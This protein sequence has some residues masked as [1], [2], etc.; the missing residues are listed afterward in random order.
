MS[1]AILPPSLPYLDL[2]GN[3]IQS[4]FIWFGVAGS[5]ASSNPIVVYWDRVLTQPASQPI[6]ILNGYTYRAGTMANVFVNA[7]DYSITI[8]NK[9]NEVVFATLS[10]YDSGFM[11]LPVGGTVGLPMRLNFLKNTNFTQNTL[12]VSGTIVLTAGQYGHNNY[13]AG[14]AG[15]TYTIA[16]VAGKSTI[17]ISAGTLKQ[18]IDSLLSDTYTLSFVGSASARINTDIYS[19]SPISSV[20]TGGVPCYVEFGVG[21]VSTVQLEPGAVANSYIP[22]DFVDPNPNWL[23]SEFPPVFIDS[24]SFSVVND[25]TSLATAGR[26]VWIDDS[27]GPRVNAIVKSSSFGSGITTIIIEEGTSAILSTLTAFYL[28]ADTLGNYSVPDIYNGGDL[29]SIS[30]A[31][32]AGTLD[33][34]TQCTTLK[35]RLT[36]LTSGDSITRPAES[37]A[38]LTVPS[39]ATLGMTNAISSKLTLL[40]IDHAGT[41]ELA[42]INNLAETH[43]NGASL[44]STTIMSAASDSVNVFY[45][46]TA[47]SNV[48]YHVLGYI[49]ITEATAGTWVTAP[50]LVY[51]LTMMGAKPVITVIPVTDKPGDIKIFS[52]TSVQTN[53][54]IVPTAP[55]NINRT[56]YSALF[57][58]LVTNSGHV[59]TAF[60]VTIASPGVFTATAHGFTGSEKIRLSTTGALPTGLNTTTDYYVLYINANTFNLSLTDG[61]AAINTSGSQSGTHS[62]LQTNWGF[63]DGSTTFGIPSLAAGESFIHGGVIGKHSNGSIPSHLH[64]F[65]GPSSANV[66]TPGGGNALFTSSAT[67]NTSSFGT[68]TT[69]LPAGQNI[70]WII[71]YL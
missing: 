62:Y 50:T 42:V 44:I 64:T 1:Q 52:G 19:L 23:L 58:A 27:A 39:G 5:E 35:F 48:A 53:W 26:R 11:E 41:V 6:G 65:T 12:K 17:T 4:G 45:S 2:D 20:V 33:L 8:R 15:C 25:I 51:G 61:G 46:A 69:N 3:A 70:Q 59:S 63:G 22:G 40:A 49:D 30:A 56:T 14:A 47:R 54:M 13:Y 34:N 18:R 9:K 37:I 57:D 66:Y 67:G 71:K 60:T 36:V 29:I 38:K 43:L 16:T 7:N 31:I 24:T 21:T 32:N 55:T 28:G 68:G 10:A